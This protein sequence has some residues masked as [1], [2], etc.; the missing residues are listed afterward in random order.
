MIGE[1]GLDNGLI[2]YK[3]RRDEKS[4]DI[5]EDEFI[6]FLKEKLGL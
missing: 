3:S 1:R 4:Q 2:E 6:N 5:N